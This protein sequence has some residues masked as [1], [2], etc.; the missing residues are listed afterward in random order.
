MDIKGVIPNDTDKLWFLVSGD[1][2]VYKH[3]MNSAPNP[4]QW[5]F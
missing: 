4:I 3:Y 2:T 5:T 1:Y